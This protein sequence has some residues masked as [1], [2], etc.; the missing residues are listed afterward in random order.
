MDNY[1]QGSTGAVPM[2]TTNQTPVIETTSRQLEKQ[3]AEL[4]EIVSAL[5][6]R[7]TPV[8]CEPEPSKVRADNP[9]ISPAQSMFAVMLRQRVQEAESLSYRLSSIMRRLEI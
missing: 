4:T 6:S 7:L 3:F 9:G 5:E 2:P 1:L 8:M